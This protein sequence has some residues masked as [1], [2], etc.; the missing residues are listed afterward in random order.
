MLNIQTIGR[1]QHPSS[2]AIHSYQAARLCRGQRIIKDENTQFTVPDVLTFGALIKAMLQGRQA[3]DPYADQ[4]LLEVERR[5]QRAFTTIESLSQQL[6]VDIKR[7]RLPNTLAIAPCTSENPARLDLNHRM[8][9]SIY[10]KQI[11]LLIASFDTYVSRLAAYKNFGVVSSHKAGKQQHRGMKAIRG[12]LMAATAYK[13]TGV[14]RSD[15]LNKTRKGEECMRRFGL[16][17]LAILDGELAPSY[18]PKAVSTAPKP[19]NQQGKSS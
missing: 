4:A 5:L 6:A 12:V 16:I 2:L 3:D 9:S 8:L 1:F 17:P 11:A 13:M 10:A 18:A 19:R 15:I 7:A 14:T